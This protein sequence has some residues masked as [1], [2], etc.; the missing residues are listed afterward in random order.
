MNGIAAE[1]AVKIFVHFEQGYRHAAPSQ[2]QRQDCAGRPATCNATGSLLTVDNFGA[3][4]LRLNRIEKLRAQGPSL[5]GRFQVRL[6]A[7]SRQRFESGRVASR[8]P[9]QQF[10]PAL[11]IYLPDF[12]WRGYNYFWER[13]EPGPRR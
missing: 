4:G 10:P 13:R 6:L 2:Q 7:R 1:F 9:L 3:S 11:Y 5:L 8:E 12:C